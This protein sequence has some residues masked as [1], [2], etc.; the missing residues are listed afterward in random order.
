MILLISTGYQAAMLNRPFERNPEGC[1]AFFGLLAR[2]YFRYDWTATLGAP[3]MSMGQGAPAIFY[4]NHPPSTPLL[5]AAVFGAF[6]Y[7]GDYLSLPG[8]WQVR[9]PT[10]LFT[11]GCIALIHWLLARRAGP[12]AGLLA[13]TI[14]ACI[15]MTLIYGG[16]PDV[17]NTQLVFFALLT[18]AAYERFHTLQSP[19]SLT[20]LSLA[21]LG[22]ALMDWPAFYLVPVLGLHFVLSRPWRSWG[23]IAAFA[24]IAT[25]IFAVEYAYLAIANRD[26]Y[27]MAWL[28]KRRALS[29]VADT[30]HQFGFTDWL[31]H[32]VWGFAVARHTIPI[33]LLAILWLVM[34]V[35]RRFGSPGDRFVGL[36][37]AWAG[38]HVLVGRQGVYQHEWWWWPLTPVLVAAAAL[39]LD[40]ILIGIQTRL[41]P[42]VANVMVGV[43][44]VA[45]GVWNG[46]R[47]VDE[48]CNPPPIMPGPYN[49]S[50]KELGE[51]I[52]ESAPPDAAVLLAESDNSLPLW[53]YADRAL[54]RH[55]WTPESL[56]SRLIDQSVDLCFE[57]P[58]PWPGR[59][60]ALIIPRAYLPTLQALASDA[61]Q[62]YARHETDRF[63]VY[64]LNQ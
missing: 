35:V 14:F 36:L 2:N 48:L 8:D 63:V 4:A 43:A 46:V 30:A 17:I 12:R 23:W 52:R 64:E 47:A 31:V 15:P 27:W 49:Y 53:Y 44:V 40:R 19:G 34:A 51:L 45:L 29:N 16:F 60:T 55:V 56:K 21:M 62:H 33:T 39:A 9:L 18:V 38:L 6:G 61:D 10:M 22:A 26:W 13:A 37:L 58:Q 59:A 20:L 5:V 24:A 42:Q 57:V 11:I 54:K 41:P 1:G 7:R 32:A 50:P 25:A 28:L 3:V